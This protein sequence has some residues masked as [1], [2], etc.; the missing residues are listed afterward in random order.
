MDLTKRVFAFM[1]AGIITVFSAAAVFAEEEEQEQIADKYVKDASM[2]TTDTDQPTLS[3]DMS[4]WQDYVKV[5]ETD[6]V[7]VSLSEDN[8][9]SYQ[10]QS[11]RVTVTSEEKIDDNDLNLNWEIWDSKN[12]HMFES[13]ADP[14]KAYR[15]IGIMLNAEDFGLE[16]FNGS[17]ITFRYRIGIGAKGKISGDTVLASVVDPE[18]KWIDGAKVTKFPINE[19]DSDNVNKYAM[20]VISIGEMDDRMTEPASSVLIMVPVSQKLNDVA[21]LY[22]DN[23]TVKLNSGAQVANLDGYNK[24]SQP[25]DEKELEIQIQQERTEVE[26]NMRGESLKSRVKTVMAVVGLAI[27]GVGVLA[28]ITIAIIKVKKRFY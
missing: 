13:A 19:T 24:S 27:L 4:K 21:V 28:G 8:K 25:K 1:L 26:R 18:G 3:F 2:I 11:L 10:G 22:L 5:A 12:Q 7:T 6:G 14:D 23:L 20:G 15:N 17:T 9:A 16:C